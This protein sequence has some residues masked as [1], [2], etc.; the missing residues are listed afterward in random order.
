M[1]SIREQAFFERVDDIGMSYY[2]LKVCVDL[3][4][5]GEPIARPN[6]LASHCYQA[7]DATIMLVH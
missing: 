2:F 6:E 3:L 7:C 4:K 1:D 5:M